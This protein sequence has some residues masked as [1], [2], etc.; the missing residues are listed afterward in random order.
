[1]STQEKNRIEAVLRDQRSIRNA[2]RLSVHTNSEESN[3]YVK[4]QQSQ[5]A[6]E[7]SATPNSK[8]QSASSTQSHSSKPTRKRESLLYDIPI[9]HEGFTD[10]QYESVQRLRD[11]VAD[12]AN[13]KSKSPQDLFKSMG[14]TASDRQFIE[15][16]L[17][18]IE[19]KPLPSLQNVDTTPFER[20]EKI[21]L[22]DEEI[23]DSFEQWM[24]KVEE[25][26]GDKVNNPTL[27]TEEEIQNLPPAP[28][29]VREAMQYM[30]SG[31]K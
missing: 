16:E 19:S 25:V 14:L 2:S 5:S 20:L 21:M 23:Y 31:K 10:E 3:S 24:K 18:E 22:E 12:P 6:P 1:M 8:A 15:S 13:L 27:L 29:K 30:L 11:V 17:R 9:S 26:V 4:K 28:L 7:S